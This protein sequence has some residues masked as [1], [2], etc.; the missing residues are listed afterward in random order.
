M[1]YLFLL[2]SDHSLSRPPDAMSNRSA[3][4]DRL[5]E[6]GNYVCSAGLDDASTATT[7]RVRE[8]KAVVTDGPFAETKELLG[9]FFV[10]DCRDLDEA[11]EYAGRMPDAAFGSVE[12]RPV[13]HPE[14]AG[15]ER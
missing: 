11:L 2:N 5:R 9:A 13:S 15:L 8:G 4:A 10:V 14:R 7:V 12:V 3:V 6:R 1:L